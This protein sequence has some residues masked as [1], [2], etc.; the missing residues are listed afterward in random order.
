[1]NAN[2]LFQEDVQRL[3]QM[4]EDIMRDHRET[5]SEIRAGRNFAEY[6]RQS[7]ALVAPPWDE[8]RVVERDYIDGEHERTREAGRR[9]NN[10]S[11]RRSPIRDHISEY[12][13]TM[14]EVEELERREEEVEEIERV[15]EKLF[16][17]D[18]HKLDAQHIFRF[19]Q[20]TNEAAKD[21]STS[22]ESAEV[23]V[24]ADDAGA[25][26]SHEGSQSTGREQ[27]DGKRID[28]TSTTQP[29]VSTQVKMDEESG[30]RPDRKRDDYY[31]DENYDEYSDDKHERGRHTSWR[32]RYRSANRNLT[33]EYDS[34]YERETTGD[35]AIRR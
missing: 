9:E 24:G 25:Q 22:N 26:V 30:P 18:A 32:G 12:E 35:I 33:P 29:E 27:Y 19:A 28:F 20:S 11:P 13:S 3:V 10:R 17:V 4:T 15:E 5:I 31:V 23:D 14:K 8:E 6:R 16:L 2:S 1:V 7:L 34:E 21:I